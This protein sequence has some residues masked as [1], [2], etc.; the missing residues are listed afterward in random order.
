MV[1]WNEKVKTEYSILKT[2]TDVE[3][4]QMHV[5]QHCIPSVSILLG[6]YV[7]YREMYNLWKNSNRPSMGP[8]HDK[9]K[10]SKKQFKRSMKQCK[11]NGDMHKANALANDLTNKKCTSF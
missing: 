9:F 8:L 7:E 6:L 2:Q 10:S 1:G 4:T 5:P 3:Y 11:N